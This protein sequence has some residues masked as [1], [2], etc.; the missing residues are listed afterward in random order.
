MTED[1]DRLMRD[2]LRERAGRVD[3]AVPLVAAAQRGARRRRG[4]RVGLA[5]ALA[6]AALALAVRVDVGLD[7][8]ADPSPAPP[9]SSSGTDPQLGDSGWR[10][11]RWHDLAVYVPA[12][13]GYGP[14][15]APSGSTSVLCGT[16]PEGRYVG[17]P[18]MA[19]DMCLGGDALPEPVAPYVWLGADVEP[20]EAVLAD[21]T[22]QETVAVAGTTLTVAADDV[23]RRRIL[24][25]ARVG[26]TCPA[27]LPEAPL[28]RLPL[29]DTGP[30][31]LVCA[32]RSPGGSYRLV[33]GQQL[34]ARA[35]D[36]FATAYDAAPLVGPEHSC[37][38]PAGLELVL[39]R[40]GERQWVVDLG[41]SLQRDPGRSGSRE[42]T[43]AS[44]QAW[45]RGVVP[46]V[47]DGPR[48]ATGAM[49]EPFIGPLG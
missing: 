42:L 49:A 25:S 13:W 28:V 26:G 44:L 21:G 29:A 7:R 10:T 11:E 23:L 15:P 9:A 3:T 17:R 37:P 5:A 40:A 16:V 18:I 19:S 34:P 2:G 1:L 12:D 35:G 8:D 46:H 6:V 33:G 48:G 43:V 20:G 14:A 4:L 30:G 24:A 22:V 31:L 36:R 45:A 47:L 38:E 27:E 41:C 32:Y 39:L